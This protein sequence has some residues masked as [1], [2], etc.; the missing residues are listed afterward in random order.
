MLETNDVR[1]GSLSGKTVVVTGTLESFTRQEAEE[2]IQRAGGKP[3]SSVSN[4]T[5]YVISGNEA[6][7]KLAKAKK[8]GITILNNNQFKELL[9]K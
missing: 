3:T 5:D 8:L 6:G 4:N 2:A 9:N 1:D 7:S